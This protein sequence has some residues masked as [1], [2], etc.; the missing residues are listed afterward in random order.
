MIEA[1]TL[2]R[3]LYYEIF[4]K[5]IDKLMVSS[6]QSELGVDITE[7]NMTRE[8]FRLLESGVIEVPRVE[9]QGLCCS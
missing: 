2:S 4:F 7:G 9:R 8:G 1:E 5:K 6:E 3:S